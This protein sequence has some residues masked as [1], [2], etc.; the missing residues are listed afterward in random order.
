MK[1]KKKFEFFRI[2]R[3]L[4]FRCRFNSKFCVDYEFINIFSK[5]LHIRPQKA[6]LNHKNLK[7][8]IKKNDIFTLCNFPP[9]SF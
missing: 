7:N 3:P 5:I 1:I 8:H 9:F 6:G 2:L 4:K